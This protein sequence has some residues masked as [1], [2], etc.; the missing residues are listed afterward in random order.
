[1][2]L[3]Q[4]AKVSSSTVLNSVYMTSA[5]Q[6]AP[7]FRGLHPLALD[8]CA[9]EIIKI[10]ILM[11]VV[12]PLRILVQSI[13]FKKSAQKREALDTEKQLKLYASVLAKLRQQ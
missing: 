4:K 10:A 6:R 11:I 5:W 7:Y 8:E 3:A 13:I 2:Q 12:M 1:M 9:P